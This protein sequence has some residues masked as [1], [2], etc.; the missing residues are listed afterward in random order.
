MP[1]DA[2]AFNLLYLAQAQRSEKVNDAGA[3]PEPGDAGVLNHLPGARPD[4]R[5]K[6]ASTVHLTPSA[7]SAFFIA[8]N[9]CAHFHFF[10]CRYKMAAG[11]P[12]NMG[13]E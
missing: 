5:R 11:S 13:A 12:Y 4:A 8:A 9:L 2:A 7:P 10:R 3:A 1:A 6:L